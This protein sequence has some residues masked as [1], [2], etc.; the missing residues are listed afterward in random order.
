MSE[1]RREDWSSLVAAICPH[2]GYQTDSAAAVSGGPTNVQPKPGD[3]SICF[4]CR[5]LAV[6]TATGLRFPTE[7]ES[8]D[9]AP[10]LT[11]YRMAMNRVD[12]EVGGR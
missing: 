5:G 6:F 12:R 2:C 8:A 9:A 10:S 3:L 1:P 11:R 4:R 7:Q